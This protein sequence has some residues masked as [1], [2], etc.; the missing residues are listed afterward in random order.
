MYIMLWHK[1]YRARQNSHQ[2]DQ[3]K[4]IDWQTQL[5]TCSNILQF[6]TERHSTCC[7][8]FNQPQLVRSLTTQLVNCSENA[9]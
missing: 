3:P 6:C 2:L 4:I 8:A 9:A 7:N 5:S 1:A